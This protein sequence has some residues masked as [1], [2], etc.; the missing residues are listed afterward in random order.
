M[1]YKNVL[2]MDKAQFVNVKGR[3][4]SLAEGIQLLIAINEDGKTFDVV[5]NRYGPNSL[6]VPVEMLQEFI[7]HFCLPEIPDIDESKAF[8]P[9][10]EEFGR[11]WD[12]AKEK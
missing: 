2:V 4:D 3:T 12:E 11:K 6:D 9:D 5:K 1:H 7:S 10:W 8:G